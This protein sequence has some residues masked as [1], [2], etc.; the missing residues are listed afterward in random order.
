[1]FNKKKIH[2]WQLA[3]LFGAIT[4]IIL[5][6]LWSQAPTQSAGMMD[7]SMGN[8]MKSM[9]LSNITIYDLFDTMGQQQEAGGTQSHHQNQSAIIINLSYLTTGT[10]FILLPLIIGG[11]IFLGIVWAR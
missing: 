6:A 2:F 1:M 11:A 9:H 10:I 3:L 4:I 7:N 8:M 5:F